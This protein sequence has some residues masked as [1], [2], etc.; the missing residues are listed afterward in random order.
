MFEI[1]QKLSD[2]APRYGVY[3][4]KTIEFI[5]SE[6]DKIGIQYQTEPYKS[7]VPY[8]MKA[9]LFA[10][11]ISIPC[12]GSSLVSGKIEN[13]DH[14]ISAFGNSG[15][16]H[17]FNISYSPITDEISVV[18]I[19]RQPS[20]TIS[21]SSVIQI[22]MA[23]EVWGSV[24]VDR[25]YF[26]SANIL[27]GNLV[28]PQT[29]VI[30]HFDSMFVGKGALDNAAAI[31]IMFEIIK[32]D[33]KIIENNLLI[34]TGNEEVSYDNYITKSGYGFRKFEERHID[35]LKNCKQ[36]IV[37]DGIG[38][39]DASFSQNGLD[40]VLQVKC[41]DEIRNKVFWLQNDQS[42]VLKYFHTKADTIK[43][44]QEKYLQQAFLSLTDKLTNP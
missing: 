40:W 23:K 8:F 43:V 35:I 16:N 41:L 7:S 25:E 37:I 32:N 39:S 17:P 24:K 1:I 34:F 22:V 26:T 12:L 18:D 10:D 28:N 44:I 38:V 14:L 5:T 20:V 31:S 21:R 33:P 19:Y 36:I 9:E 2:I 29:I 4:S 6:L 27:V 15:E 30:A 3:E 13:G 42:E 11:N